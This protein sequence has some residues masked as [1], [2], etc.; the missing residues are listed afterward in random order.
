MVDWERQ[1]KEIEAYNLFLSAFKGVT[2]ENGFLQNGFELPGLFPTIEGRDVEAQPD[3]VL[4]DGE[5]LLLV[6]VKQGDNFEERHISQIEKFE[7]VYLSMGHDQLTAIKFYLNMPFREENEKGM[8]K[9][10]AGWK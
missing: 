6:E 7:E 8:E 3:F 5:I 9:W 4:Y 2:D 10:V 1:K